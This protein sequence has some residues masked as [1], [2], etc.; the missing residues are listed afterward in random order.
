MSDNIEKMSNKKNMYSKID[1]SDFQTVEKNDDRKKTSEIKPKEKQ[2][3]DVFLDSSVKNNKLSLNKDG[4]DKGLRITSLGGMEEIGKNMCVVEFDQD[5][6]IIDCGLGFPDNELPGIDYVIPD[7]T[8]IIENKD[9]LKGLVITHGHEDHIG[10][11]PYLLKL[12]NM[13]VYGTKLSLGLIEAKLEEHNM[14]ADLHPFIPGDRVT[15]GCFSIEAIRV[16]HSI[17][18]AVALAVFTPIG[19]VIHTGDFKIDYTPIVGDVID[20]RRFSEL[21]SNGVLLL[22]SDSTNAEKYGNTISESVVGEEFER[23][24]FRAVGRRIVIASFASNIQRIQQIVDLAHKHNRKIA[25]SGRSMESYT[26]MAE[27]L[28]YLDFKQDLL[29]G[30]EKVNNYRDEDIIIITTGSQ[31]EPMSAL[32]RMANGTHRQISITSNDFVIISANPVPGNEQMVYKTVN[33]LFKLGAEV[34]Y[35][36]M[37]DVHAS[38][39]ACRDDLKM[40]INLINPKFFIPIHGEYRQLV[41]H[42]DIALSMGVGQQ[43]ILIPSIGQTV[44]VTKKNIRYLREVPSGRVLVDG[45]GVGDVGTV[46]LRDRHLLSQDGLLVVVVTLDEVTGELLSGPDLLSRGFVFVRESE[47]LFDEI[48]ETVSDIFERR[49]SYSRKR[50]R[51]DLNLEIREEVSSLVYKRTKRNPMILPM[52]LDI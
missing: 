17:P 49:S 45:L 6:F 5:M 3:K 47:E 25:I 51:A 37:Y 15:L 2:N 33:E 22:M 43:N 31:G 12:V 20:L 18:D 28:G 36:S 29:I 24:F 48:K 44:E 42:K 14:Q 1:I 16:N 50:A 26:N 13:P 39:H 32:T 38:G 35:E 11:V 30:I 34:I 23:L 19:T 10:A 21:G 52:I 9:R 4:S 7:F 8:Y 41:K 40:L 46:V 27:K